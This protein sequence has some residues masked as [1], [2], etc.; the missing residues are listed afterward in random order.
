MPAP[1][2]LKELKAIVG[3]EHVLTAPEHLAAYSYDATFLE[4]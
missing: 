1:A 3:A 4:H 2:I